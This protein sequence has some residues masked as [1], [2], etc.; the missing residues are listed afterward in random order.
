MMKI[1]MI[2]LRL[3]V[4]RLELRYQASPSQLTRFPSGNCLQPVI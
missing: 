4:P 1:R 3:T 2:A